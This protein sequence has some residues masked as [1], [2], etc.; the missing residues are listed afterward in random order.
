MIRTYI[1]GIP[2]GFNL[3][4]AESEMIDYFKSYYIAD[5]R[6]RRLEV[7]RRENGETF[8]N[9][10]R[11][12]LAEVS[13]SPQNAFF[14]MSLVIDGGRYISD[15]KTL[16]EFMDLLFDKLVERNTLLYPDS[17]GVLR[18]KVERFDRAVGDVNWL[19][20]NLPNILKKLETTAYDSSFAVG[21]PG[22]IATFKSDASQRQI[23]AALH[24][25]NWVSVCGNITEE[26]V[27]GSSEPEEELDITY[28]VSWLNS[29]NQKLVPIAISPTPDSLPDLKK[30]HEMAGKHIA[31]I[32]QQM[33]KLKT[34]VVFENL[35]TLG[36][37]ILQ[38]RN[39]LDVL[40][41]KLTA[42]NKKEEAPA[43]NHPKPTTPPQENGIQQPSGQVEPTTKSCFNCQRTLPLSEF[44]SPDAIICRECERKK[45]GSVSGETGGV[46]GTTPP[47]NP[48]PKWL[49]AGGIT[50]AL[51]VLALGLLLLPK[52]CTKPT[53]FGGDDSVTRENPVNEEN[54]I[55]PTALS[56]ALSGYN[57]SEVYNLL[58]KKDDS[59]DYYARVDDTIVEYLWKRIEKSQKRDIGDFWSNNTNLLKMIGYSDIDSSRKAWGDFCNDYHSIKMALEKNE[60]TQ[61]EYKNICKKIDDNKYIIEKKDRNLPQQWKD[62]LQ[63]KIKNDGASDHNN[64]TRV[65]Q[66][67]KVKY[68]DKNGNPQTKTVTGKNNDNSITDVRPES[69]VTITAVNGVFGEGNNKGKSKTTINMG[70]YNAN[71][72]ADNTT[73]VQCSPSILIY[74]KVAA[75][76]L[77]RR[78]TM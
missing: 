45:D 31:S 29:T 1:Y 32:K 19:K 26:D 20:G 43:E 7:N 13:R 39:Q 23:M 49:L 61:D 52:Q 74:L 46:D 10:L 17:N 65:A 16:V 21:E 71:S 38:L 8:Y 56:D 78:T 41:G 3:Y 42:D 77:T 72:D 60:I 12:G 11:Y 66:T 76:G 69:T 22:K 25:Y 14:G 6:G 64:G 47:P 4:E 27:S 34:G 59:K 2:R 48:T 33:F 57:F 5:R 24:K 55:D 30:W 50:L 58:D 35:H 18:Y 37:D 68:T 9:Y 54:K 75:P 36:N 40:I 70:K 53:S 28:L 63:G 62:A 73:R 44:S 67:F 51:I 15:L